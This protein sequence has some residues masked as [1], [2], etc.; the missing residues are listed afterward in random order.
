MQAD[1]SN[2]FVEFGLFVCCMRT[3][4]R[5]VLEQIR[6]N[7]G[8]QRTIGGLRFVQRRSVRQFENLEGL[9]EGKLRSHSAPI[10][11]CPTEELAIR[12]SELGGTH[13]DLQSVALISDPENPR[14]LPKRRSLLAGGVHFIKF[15][16]FRTDRSMLSKGS[17]ATNPPAR[18]LPSRLTGLSGRFLRLPGW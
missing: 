1:D 3:Q 17:V 2:R 13:R 10:W 9:C 14:S 4:F 12:R 6:V 15:V 16:S 11:F 18:G 8:G 5:V 7:L